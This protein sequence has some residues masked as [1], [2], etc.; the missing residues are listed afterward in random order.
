MEAA[1]IDWSMLVLTFIVGAGAGALI[2]HLLKNNSGGSDNPDLKSRMNEK[3]LQ[4]AQLTENVSEH[5]VRTDELIDNLE[6]NYQSLVSHL[7]AGT[8]NFC[9]DSTLIKQSKTT[10]ETASE[11]PA[12]EKAEEKSESAQPMDYAPQ[13]SGTLAEDFGLTKEKDKE[14]SAEPP[15]GL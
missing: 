3:E 14:D 5:F 15:K 8:E 7:K 12:E 6:K 11:A 9:D 10:S 4:L 13:S 1:N 2:T